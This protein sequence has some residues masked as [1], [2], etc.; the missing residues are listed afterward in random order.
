[1]SWEWWAWGK[2]RRSE[3]KDVGEM[4]AQKKKKGR[5]VG[6]WGRRSRGKQGPPGFRLAGR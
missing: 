3:G 6:G 2:K 5:R 4:G 1:M